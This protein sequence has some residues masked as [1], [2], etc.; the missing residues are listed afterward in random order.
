MPAGT[1]RGPGQPLTGSVSDVA[2]LL[3]APVLISLPILV[4]VAV[5]FVLV[6]GG[7]IVVL[8]GVYWAVA[9]F[10]ALIGLAAA[11][12]RKA[13]RSRTRPVRTGFAVG[14]STSRS[15]LVPAGVIAATPSAV[16]LRSDRAAKP[17]S[18][19]VDRR[20]MSLHRA[21]GIGPPR[22]RGASDGTIT[23]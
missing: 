2:I 14:R 6:P 13:R 20:A 23:R 1:R 3:Y 16:G 4:P 8:A 19:L 5:I 12:R 17:P 9:Q 7:F 21:A 18:M 11:R 22:G 15:P 10:I